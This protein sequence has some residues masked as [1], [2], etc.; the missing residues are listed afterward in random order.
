MQ[1]IALPVVILMLFLTGCAG[2]VRSTLID[3]EQAI[4]IATR[5]ATAL[6]YDV[7]SM[8]VRAERVSGVYKIALRPT[9]PQ[10]GGDVTISVDSRT[11]NIITVRR[12][13]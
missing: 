2:P 6:G 4:Q 13:Q 11:S 8:T 12:G 3:K 5:K 10:F 1:L 7:R 9:A